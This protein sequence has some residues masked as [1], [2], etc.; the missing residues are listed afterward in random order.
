MLSGNF[1]S[2]MV[3][4]DL[5]TE[6]QAEEAQAQANE[7]GDF[8]DQVLINKGYV[9]ER[10]VLK[11][12]AKH[13]GYDYYEK[14]EQFAVPEE[15]VG[16]VPIA[17]ARRYHFVAIGKE[18]GA[19][20]VAICQPL[21]LLAL[22]DLSERLGCEV[23]PVLVP[24]SEIASLINKHYSESH[25]AL[26]EALE[27]FGIDAFE[28]GLS[29]SEDLLD[30]AN[31]AP[32]IRLVNNIL[33]RALKMR[34]SDIH[35]HPLEDK[36]QARYRIDGVLYDM[37]ELP[38]KIQDAVIT[39]V[40]VL[41]K[42]DIAE[43]RLPQDGRASYKVGD[44]EVDL[45]ISSVPTAYG[46]R[47]V[48]RIL[49]KS[50]RLFLLEEIG[51]D[52]ETL[53][54]MR[55]FIHSPNGIVLVTGPT[56][57]GKTT[58][59][60]AAL[61]E[62]NS[63]EKNVLTIEDPIEYHLSGISQVQVSPKKG[64]TFAAGLRSFLRQDPDVMMV[65]EIRDPE[66]A[67]ISIQAAQTGHLVFS[68]LHTNDSAGA[69][70]RMLDIGVEPYLVSSSLICVIAQR[71]VRLICE[72]CR[73]KS[74]PDLGNLQDLGITQL[75]K[76]RM[77][78]VGRGCEKCMGTGY[79]DRSGIY[80]LMPVTEEVRSLIVRREGSNK[81]KQAALNSGMRTLRQDGVRKVLSG[82]TTVKEVMAVTMMD[83]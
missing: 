77:L 21:N 12:F 36:L 40:K 29:S 39:R 28:D 42:M 18:N 32:I 65:G 6:A 4:S 60:Y 53:E 66:T 3:Q 8:L 61:H 55:R 59:L 22:D 16:K 26:G 64:L 13:Y 83:I 30:V 62:I 71:L 7:T 76:D 75:P 68:T 45:R 24:K 2:D 44:S 58:T 15:F 31:K 63:A 20:N 82:Q 19:Y 1:I 52:P 72:N 35:L 78:W 48:F 54:P 56:G 57:S 27:D 47:I 43:R 50:A 5:L 81:I 79:W 74:K 70:T 80:E 41:G 25:A 49:D 11:F 69:V 38:K 37:E 9:A 10:E 46:E 17:F 23:E 33:F 73:E 14:I 34:A 67:Q 51:I